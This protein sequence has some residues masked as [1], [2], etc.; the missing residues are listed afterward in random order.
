MTWA[1]GTESQHFQPAD[2]CACALCA[3]RDWGCEQCYRCTLDAE[4][5]A[6]EKAEARGFEYA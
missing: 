6:L 1:Y 4:D 2:P 3:D 5:I